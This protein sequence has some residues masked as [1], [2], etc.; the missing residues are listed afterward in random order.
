MRKPL[1]TISLAKSRQN[2]IEILIKKNLTCMYV[3]MYIKLLNFGNS[4]L[5]DLPERQE[6]PGP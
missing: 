5:D 2:D 1:L 6:N 4:V 3:E